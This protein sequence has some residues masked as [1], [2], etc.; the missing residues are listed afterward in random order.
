MPVGFCDTDY[1]HATYPCIQLFKII[2]G[3]NL[4]KDVSQ[5]DG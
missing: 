5:Q 4:T 3:G 1:A 2:D